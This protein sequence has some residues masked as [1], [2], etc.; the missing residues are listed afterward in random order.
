MGP[1]PCHTSKRESGDERRVAVAK[2]ARALI[3]EKGLEGLRTRDIAE[4]V[5]INIATLHYHVPTKEALVTLV[6]E[7]LRSDFKAQALRRPR[8]G[9]SGLAQ[10]REEFVEFRETLSDMP[11]LIGVISELS[12]RAGRD[13]AIAN[14]MVPMQT[15]WTNQFVQIFRDGIADGSFRHDVD[16]EAAAII[17]TSAM[18]ECWRPHRRDRLEAILAEFERSFTI[19][20][21]S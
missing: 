9:L 7:S 10:L 14:I 19:P 4:R 20:S 11:D 2:A 8:A 3:M 17:V 1:D 16:P 18:A 6:A 12:D 5:G 15:F 13:P 21:A